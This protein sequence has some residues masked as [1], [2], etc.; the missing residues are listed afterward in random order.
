LNNFYGPEE[1]AAAC[2]ATNSGYALFEVSDFQGALAAFNEAVRLWPD[3]SIYWYDIARTL[4]ELGTYDEALLA[5][6]KA[7][8]LNDSEPQFWHALGNVRR[9]LKD[10]TG[11]TDAFRHALKL[12][13]TFPAFNNLGL[14]YH[15]LGRLSR[16]RDVLERGLNLAPEDTDLLQNLAAV[17]YNLDRFASAALYDRRAASLNPSLPKVWC[18]L[19]DDYLKLKRYGMAL[20]AIKKAISLDGDSVDKQAILQSI[21]LEKDKDRS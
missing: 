15:E 4:R 17:M 1:E 13:P 9:S 8:E 21:L 16:A 5:I 19:A 2:K 7:L 10:L 20:R 3:Q 14:T 6:N 12:D 18:H 11:A